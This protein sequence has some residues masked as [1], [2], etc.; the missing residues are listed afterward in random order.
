MAFCQVTLSANAGV[1][2]HLGPTRIWSD[3]L[4]NHKIPGFSTLTPELQ[5][6]LQ[7][8]P[9]FSR[10]D[11]IFFTHCHLDHY[12]RSLTELAL[13]QNP[14]ALA[15]LPEPAFERQLLLAGERCRLSLGPVSAEFKRLPHEGREYAHVPHY[16]CLL[17]CGGFRVLIPGDCALAAPALQEFIGGSGIH[18]ALVDFPWITLQ[19]GRRFLEQVVHPEHLLVY[20]LP[21]PWDDRWGYRRAAEKASSLLSAIPDVRL[22]L[23]PFQRE[24]VA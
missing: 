22:L 3:A 1:A 24:T 5:L 13:Q 21:F 16:G 14:Q 8:H 17:E 2:L 4:H 10:P 12:S 23:S 20:H 7:S 6:A 9:D 18:L 19:R 11:L 15:A